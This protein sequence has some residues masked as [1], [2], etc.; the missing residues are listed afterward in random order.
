[1]FDKCFAWKKLVLFFV[2]LVLLVPVVAA[3]SQGV[4]TP[5]PTLII[6][7][8]PGP[9]QPATIQ[10]NAELAKILPFAD[11]EAFQDAQRG[12]ITSLPD[13]TIKTETGMPVW[14]LKGFEFLQGK[15]PPPSVNPSLWRMA[16]LNM[17]NGLFKVTDRVY[18]VRGFDMSNMTIIEGD[19]GLI[20][21]DPLSTVETSR[22]GLNL[23]FQQFGQK[24]VVAVIYTHSH[25]DHYGGVK[26]VVSTEDV[27][28]ARVSILAPEGF[29]AAAVSENVYAGTAMSRRAGYQYGILLPRGEFGQVDNGLGKS[30]P[31]GTITLIPPT[32][33]I[34]KT[35]ESRTIDG[36][37]IQFQMV[38]GT[39][40]PAEMTLYFPQFKVLDAAEIACPLLHNILTLRGAQVRDAKKWATSLNEDIALYGDKTEILIAQHHWPCWGRENVVAFLANQRDLYE[41]INDQTLNL[42]NQGYTPIEISE[43]IQL[44]ASL[45]QQWYTHGYYGSLSHDVKAVYQKYLGWYD[46]NPANLN[47]LTPVEA[48]RKFVDYMGGT[49]AIITKAREDFQKGEYRWVAQVLNQVVFAEPDNTEARFLEADALAQLGYQAEAGTWRNIYL[50]GAWELRNG[51]IMGKDTGAS[52]SPDTIRAMTMPLFFDYMGVRLNAAK[53]NGKKIILNWNFTDTGEQYTLNLSN[54]A[55]TYLADWQ[56]PNADA[57]VTLSRAV[58]DALILLETTIEKEL[59]AGQIK[60]EGKGMKFAELLGML[61][62]FS[63]N[64]PIVTP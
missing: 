5:S 28:S 44:P 50:V 43:T 22:A 31:T 64:F 36:V 62:T 57:T 23:Y 13:M 17:N 9:A 34:G 51:I 18:Q 48:A 26:G 63:L 21:I 53:A 52:A 47:P 40:A 49:Q 54:C 59:S 7:P 24:P 15:E 2:P 27:K 33:I 8:K 61:D 10:Y 58:L 55:L 29:L 35:G 37:E 14:T 12:F 11:Q 38:S 16:Q 1:M 39:E 42:I 4:S 20:L 30:F 3:C 32:D 6:L 45:S 25:I 56:A 41:F 19:S 60:V 46:G